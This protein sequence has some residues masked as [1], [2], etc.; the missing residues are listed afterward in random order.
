MMTGTTKSQERALSVVLWYAVLVTS[1][2]A[3]LR[4]ERGPGSGGPPM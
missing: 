1:M 4:Q 3:G 2:P